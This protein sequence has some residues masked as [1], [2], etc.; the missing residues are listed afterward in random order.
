[1]CTCACGA[2]FWPPVLTYLECVQIQLRQ[3]TVHLICQILSQVTD[4]P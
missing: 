1:M 2:L 3:I 4:S